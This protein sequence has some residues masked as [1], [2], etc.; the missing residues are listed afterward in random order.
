MS[1]LQTNEDFS[2]EQVHKLFKWMAESAIHEQPRGGKGGLAVFLLQCLK[3]NNSMRSL[4]T[5][6]GRHRSTRCSYAEY[7]NKFVKPL[8]EP[9]L[10]LTLAL[11]P[12]NV[13][14]FLT[15]RLR[16]RS[17]KM[18]SDPSCVGKKSPKSV[19]KH[20]AT[21]KHYVITK[22]KSSS[23]PQIPAFRRKQ[24]PVKQGDT[25]HF[26]PQSNYRQSSQTSESPPG[27]QLGK[28]AI[29][30]GTIGLPSI[31]RK[32]A[33]KRIPMSCP[34]LYDRRWPS[35]PLVG[36]RP[37]NTKWH[38]LKTVS[39]KSGMVA[40][41]HLALKAPPP[42][43][44]SRRNDLNFIGLTI[45][46]RGSQTDR[47]AGHVY[48]HHHMSH[49]TDKSFGRDVSRRGASKQNKRRIARALLFDTFGI[50][51]VYVDAI[52][53]TRFYR[54]TQ[55][56]EIQETPPDGISPDGHVS[57]KGID[58]FMAS[59]YGNRHN[60]KPLTEH[61]PLT[62]LSESESDDITSSSDS[63]TDEHDI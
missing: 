20:P 29:N 43:L 41:R 16:L 28:L 51:E 45:P 61:K 10:H 60:H 49:N 7:G 26:T 53:N 35:T 24:N 36:G 48:S 3:G 13:P 21:T 34:P 9:L 22:T 63:G 58:G 30:L 32:P 6:E 8:L 25:S 50:W 11:K 27:N 42:L 1:A 19:E 18:K 40:R 62:S 47:L 33:R 38:K 2:R 57:M 56:G 17:L 59:R 52:N 14:A 31:D 4:F 46:T 12:S 54:N 23:L 55:N 5:L 44:H 39:P 37:E 15:R